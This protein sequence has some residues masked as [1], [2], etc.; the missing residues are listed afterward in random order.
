VD[1]LSQFYKPFG[2]RGCFVEY[3]YQNLM[4]QNRTSYLVYSLVLTAISAITF[5]S[6]EKEI[7]IDLPATEPKIVVEGT[8]F[9]GQPPIIFL[10][11]TQGYFEP[12]DINT[13]TD[14]YISDPTV[15]A[16]ISDGVTSFPL[17]PLCLSDLPEEFQD[18]VSEALGIPISDLAGFDICAFTNFDLIGQPG[19]LY[20]LNVN[21]Q[22]K[23]LVS[24]TK[25]PELVELDTLWFD[26]VS[27]FPDDSLG[28]IFGNITDPDTMGNAYRWFAKRINHY[29]MWAEDEYLRGE[30]KDTRYI[31]PLGSVFDDEFFNGL[32]FEF[33]YYRGDEPNTG[34]F[35]DLNIERGFFKRG[36]T[37]AVRGCTIDRLAFRFIDSF[38]TQVGS[39]GSPFS[40]PANLQTNV[41]GGLGAF[42]GYGAVYDTV[43]CY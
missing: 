42:I 3:L 30:Q 2:K 38:E 11:W 41:S 43:V 29:P 7:T 35:D 34:K 22:G 1:I 28:F 26:V 14:L 19:T 21:Y 9:S 40:I 33:A 16:S 8:L 15:V 36:D 10:S 5:Y 4:K 37:V 13:I 24:S 32:S 12:T 20:T 39:Q 18:D 25:V 31:A 17:T 6:C 27:S 23:Q